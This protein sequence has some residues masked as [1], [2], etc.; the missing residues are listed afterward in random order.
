MQYYIFN[1]W[2]TH[3]DKKFA[4]WNAGTCKFCTKY[5]KTLED[6]AN[7]EICSVICFQLGFFTCKIMCNNLWV[8]KGI[9]LVNF[10]I[11]DKRIYATAY[12]KTL[13][14]LWHAFQNQRWDL[15]TDGLILLLTM[16]RL[17]L[18][19]QPKI[20]LSLSCRIFFNLKH[21]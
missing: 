14:L 17:I 6:P 13:E 3:H 10:T 12:G 21:L 11:R 15:L 16:P 1:D 4:W 5:L 7:W 19:V 8:W 2:E 18:L 20:L 9:L